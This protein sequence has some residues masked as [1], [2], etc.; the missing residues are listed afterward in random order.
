MKVQGVGYLSINPSTY[1]NAFPKFKSNDFD[2]DISLERQG[3]GYKYVSK[4]EQKRKLEIANKK[5]QEI[6]MAK[7]K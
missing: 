1:D 7:R 5:K 6:A 3:N 4:I 2:P